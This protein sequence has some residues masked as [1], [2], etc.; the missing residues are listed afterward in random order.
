MKNIELKE[1]KEIQVAILETVHEFC[2][3]NNIKYSLACGDLLVCKDV[4]YFY[5]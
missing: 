3:N 5:Y 2:L 4:F 1:F